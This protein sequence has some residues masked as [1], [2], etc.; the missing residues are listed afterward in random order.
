MAYYID[1][2]LPVEATKW[3][4]YLIFHS[5]SQNSLIDFDFLTAL[6]LW[7]TK[8]KFKFVKHT[9]AHNLSKKFQEIVENW[10]RKVLSD[11]IAG[12]DSVASP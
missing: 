5:N 1:N 7:L 4:L 6:H 10:A 9:L 11:S 12:G 2:I 8:F 3:D